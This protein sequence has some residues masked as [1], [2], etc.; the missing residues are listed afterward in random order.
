MSQPTAI[1]TLQHA[2]ARILLR[3]TLVERQAQEVNKELEALGK[4]IHEELG[5]QMDA[6]AEEWTRDE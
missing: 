1:E 5:E 4:S 2:L 3:E 6:L